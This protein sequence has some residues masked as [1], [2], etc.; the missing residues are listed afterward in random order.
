[1][2]TFPIVTINDELLA[3]LE[4]AA[5]KATPG[6]WCTDGDLWVMAQDSDQLNNGFVIAICDGP[7]GRKN[8]ESMAKANPATIKALLANIADLKQ[9]LVAAGITAENCE[10]LRKDAERYQWLRDSGRLIGECMDSHESNFC[11]CSAD[12]ED[13]LWFEQLDAA[14]DAA[15]SAGGGS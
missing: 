5:D 10:M 2:T 3:E 14:I 12:G 8:A 1:M 4:A 6:K 11:V 9:Q 7:D 13:V 15:R